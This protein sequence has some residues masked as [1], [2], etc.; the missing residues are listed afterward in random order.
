MRIEASSRTSSAGR[1]GP[2][3]RG[4]AGA[5]FSVAAEAEA[6][7]VSNAGPIV[8]TAGIEALLALQA[9][10]D[11]MHARRKAVRRGRTLLDALDALKADL[12]GGQVSEGRL[13]QLM[14]VVS[15]ARERGLPGLDDVLD[16][17]ELRARVELAKFGRFAGP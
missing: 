3:A 10:D 12:L 17:V 14:A 8:A 2:I 5:G 11:P 7:P 13:N 4:G 9:A 16:D 6:A 15:S 1:S